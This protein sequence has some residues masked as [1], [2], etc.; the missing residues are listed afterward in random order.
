[1]K[2]RVCLEI[3]LKTRMFGE[4][5]RKSYKLR[6]LAHI[7]LALGL[8]SCALFKKPVPLPKYEIVD[9]IVHPGKVKSV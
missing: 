5:M 4:K 3:M 6:S 2:K 1:M 7:T 9:Q 8:T